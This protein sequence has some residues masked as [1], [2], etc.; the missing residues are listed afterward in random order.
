MVQFIN[1]A[2]REGRSARQ[3]LED[4]IQLGRT[5]AAALIERI[6]TEAPVDSI[7]KG[8]ALRFGTRDAPGFVPGNLTANDAPQL[9]MG[10]GDNGATIHKNALGQLGQRAGVPGAYLGELAN[11][12]AWQRRL[13]AGILN[14][15]YHQGEGGS[16]YL[17]RAVKGEV[18]GFLSDRFRRLDNRPLVDAFAGECAKVGAVPV[19]GTSSDTRVSLKALVPQIYEPIPGE[20]IAFG[21]DWGNSDFGNGQH[22]LRAFMLRVWCLNGATTENAL[23]QIHLGRGISDDMELSQRTYELDTRTSISALRDVV[24]ATLTPRKIEAMCA[25]IARAHE[26]KVDWKSARAGLAKK[27]LKSELKAVEDAF[28]SQDVYNLPAGQTMWRMS[29]AVSW[30]AGQKDVDAD[31]KLDLQRIAGQLVNGVADRAMAEAA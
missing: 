25:G 4:K 21:V 2:S 8:S 14:E 11:G 27:L 10:Y 15:H 26:E 7:A 24:R 13:A 17:V 22:F 6:H 20:V 19:D 29:N 5:S 31:R 30:I 28:E 1:S 16:R 9:V 23:S 18:R 3:I 12:A